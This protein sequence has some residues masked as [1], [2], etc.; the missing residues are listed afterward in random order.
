MSE[1]RSPIPAQRGPADA[2]PATTPHLIPLAELLA[3]H[4]PG[5]HRVRLADGEVWVRMDGR[6]IASVSSIGPEGL[7][8]HPLA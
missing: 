6:G 1:P 3:W 7:A 2:E 5:V 4:H 8:A